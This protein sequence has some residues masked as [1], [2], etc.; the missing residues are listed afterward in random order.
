MGIHGASADAMARG[1][2]DAIGGNPSRRLAQNPDYR[3]AYDAGYM[4][5]EATLERVTAQARARGL[6]YQT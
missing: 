4:D 1:Y 2:R 5:G 3:R 6:Q